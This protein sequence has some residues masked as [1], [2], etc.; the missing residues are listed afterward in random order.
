M[1]APHVTA[2]PWAT[3]REVTAAR[4]GLG[5]AGVSLPTAV[6]LDFRMAHARARDAVHRALDAAAVAAALAPAGLPVVRAHGAVRDRGEY[7]RRPDLGRRLD[8]ASRAALAGARPAA[9]DAVFV[10]ADG[11]SALAVERHAPPLLLRVAARLRAEGWALGPVAVVEQGRVAVGDEVGELLGAALVAVLIGE[12]PGLSA[13]DSLGV[14]L[15]FA[16]RPGRTDAERN[17]ISNVRAEGLG[18]DLAAHRL[19]WMM[20]E[21]R[22]RGLTGVGLREEAPPLPP[23]ERPAVLGGGGAPDAAGR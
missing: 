16:P 6:E 20:T 10:V 4:V 23:G 9:A 2:D 19:A 12:R 8:A 14:Y 15:T 1:S 13:P 11:L 17:C 5:H 18:Y 7:L 21:A 3:L 22:R